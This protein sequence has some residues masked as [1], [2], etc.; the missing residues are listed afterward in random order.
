MNRVF[1]LR[2]I[3]GCLVKKSKAHR[4]MSIGNRESH[5]MVKQP[6]RRRQKCLAENHGRDG[7]RPN[8]SMAIIEC[9][10]SPPDRS[11]E[12]ALIVPRFFTKAIQPLDKVRYEV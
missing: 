3:S 6:S 5:R 8:K 4:I 7:C 11:G 9:L 10:G 1:Q 12:K 2:G